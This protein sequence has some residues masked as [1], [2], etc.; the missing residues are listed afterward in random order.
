M[1][2]F[3]DGRQ[4]RDEILLLLK[5]KYDNELDIFNNSMN[6]ELLYGSYETINDKDKLLKLKV[7]LDK[8]KNDFKKKEKEVYKIMFDY[9]LDTTISHDS[10]HID[11]FKKYYNKNKNDQKE[12]ID[13]VIDDINNEKVIDTLHDFI[14]IKKIILN[15]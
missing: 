12:Y 9:F 8:Y 15:Y 1:V 4:L 2:E 5:N 6:I 14:E 3:S 11:L 13:F 10:E 7:I